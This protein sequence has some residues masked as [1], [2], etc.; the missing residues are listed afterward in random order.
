MTQRIYPVRRKRATN[1]VT[2]SLTAVSMLITR[3]VFK[4]E[5]IDTPEL[6]CFRVYPSDK[7]LSKR[8]KDH[9][10]DCVWIE[11]KLFAKF[12]GSFIAGPYSKDDELRL[13]QER[14]SG[15][16]MFLSERPKGNSVVFL[17]R[18]EFKQEVKTLRHSSQLGTLFGIMAQ[19]EQSTYTC[20]HV[21]VFI[22]DRNDEV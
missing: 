11:H 2:A 17:I 8:N 19:T 9:S 20:F 22:C 6:Q 10:P 16:P 1:C 21:M 13:S 7:S 15:I 4:G 5:P 14:E 18:L 12:R 3:T